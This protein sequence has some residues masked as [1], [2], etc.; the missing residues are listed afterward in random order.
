VL[1]ANGLSKDL[2]RLDASVAG[3]SLKLLAPFRAQQ[4]W[5]GRKPYHKIGGNSSL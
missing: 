5:N 4:Y 3:T 2:E 1:L